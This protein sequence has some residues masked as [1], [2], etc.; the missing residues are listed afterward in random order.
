MSTEIT[1]AFMSCGPVKIAFFIL[2]N[3]N[4]SSYVNLQNYCSVNI[5][6]NPPL[7]YL[8]K[9]SCDCNNQQF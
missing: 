3:C 2:R 8:M 6:S 4:E 5:L 1:S 9:K 7:L